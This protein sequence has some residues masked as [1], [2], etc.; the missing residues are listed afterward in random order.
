MNNIKNNFWGA[1]R[2]IAGVIFLGLS[3][4]NSQIFISEYSEGSGSGNKYLE[5]YN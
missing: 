2:S 1:L 5:I 3:I 4:A